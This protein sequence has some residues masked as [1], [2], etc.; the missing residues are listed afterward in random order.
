MQGITSITNLTI[1]NR[2]T[3]RT[4]KHLNASP[5]ST[6]TVVRQIVEHVVKAIATEYGVVRFQLSLHSDACTIVEIQGCITNSQRSAFL[7][8]DTLIDNNR[9]LRLYGHIFG[10]GKRLPLLSIPTI[11]AQIDLLLYST[12]KCKQ[13]I[14]FYQLRFSIHILKSC[15][16]NEYANAVTLS[17]LQIGS[18]RI[19]EC[20]INIDTKA[21][22]STSF[23]TYRA[24]TNTVVRAIVNPERIG[25]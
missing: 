20:A 1:V 4:R 16:L 9:C 25:G 3:Y 22:L 7:H 19:Q 15:N 6:N 11:G 13:Q 21:R 12:L 18:Y 5:L 23:Q 10:D 8:M 17:N 24:Q 2:A 14:V